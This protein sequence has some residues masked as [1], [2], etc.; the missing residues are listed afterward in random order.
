MRQEEIHMERPLTVVSLTM[1]T[2]SFWI[3]SI[4]A[5]EAAYYIQQV[6]V[7]TRIALCTRKLI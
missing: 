4:V 6:Y 2:G 5:S 3:Q 7:Y 1:N